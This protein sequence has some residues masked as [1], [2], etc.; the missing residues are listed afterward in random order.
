MRRVVITGMGTVCPVGSSVVS[1]WENICNGVSGI[2]YPTRFNAQELGVYA[3]AECEEFDTEAYLNKRE[4]KRLDRYG[5]FNIIAATQA[6]DDAKLLDSGYNPNSIAVVSGVGIGGI[7]TIISEHEQ[8]INKGLRS[9]S[10]YFVPKSIMNLAAGMISIKYGFYGPS[11]AITTAC[12][13]GADAIGNAYTLIK[14]GRA[15]AAVAGGAEA[16]LEPLSIAGFAKIQAL[17][18]NPDHKTACRPFDRDRDGF[19]MG[20]GAAYIVLED[21]E[22]AI[23]RGAKIYC[24]IAGYGQTCDAY[25]ITSPHPEC[26]GSVDAMGLAIGEAGIMSTEVDYIN[27]H[28]TSTPLNDVNETNAIKKLFKDHAEHLLVSSTKS[29]TG[30]LM[31]AAGALEAIITAK[32]VCDDYAPPTIA[33]KNLDPECTLDYVLEKGRQKKIRAAMSNS[34]GFGGQNAALLFKKL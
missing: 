5:I 25:H 29:M 18:V 8:S 15:L 3:C 12:S 16:A 21:M 32:A 20:E 22:S 19:V 14:N 30:H 17:S 2:N 23:A 9:V 34:F 6:V 13:S 31:G 27:A 24:E 10:P 33:T 7:S 11:Y 28:G 1:A 26:R 4:A